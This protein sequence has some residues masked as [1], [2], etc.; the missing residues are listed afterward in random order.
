MIRQAP[1]EPISVLS[2]H[3]D[4]RVLV[5]GHEREG[6]GDRVRARCDAIGS[7]PGSGRVESLNVS[8]A[9]GILMAQMKR[10]P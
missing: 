3:W 7:I 10:V 5:V 2:F 8:V 9:A 1:V 4:L 6:R